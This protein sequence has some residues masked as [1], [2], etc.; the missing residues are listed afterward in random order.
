M[1]CTR[2]ARQKQYRT[3]GPLP[4]RYE[5][6]Y[7]YVCNDVDNPCGQITAG[8]LLNYN[9]I[10]SWGEPG[11]CQTKTNSEDDVVN[12]RAHVYVNQMTPV[13]DPIAKSAPKRKRTP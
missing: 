8:E 4:P 12:L 6:A 1:G 10:G 5:N 9:C 3:G 13:S 11:K 2:Q 7:M